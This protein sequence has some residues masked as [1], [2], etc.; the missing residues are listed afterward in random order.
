VLPPEVEEAF[1]VHSGRV[2]PRERLVYRPALLGSARLHFVDSRRRIDVWRSLRVLAPLTEGSSG[3]DPWEG[4]E[5]LEESAAAVVDAPLPGAAFA[6]LPEEATNPKSYAAWA[7]ALKAFVYRSQALTLWKAIALGVVSEPGESEAEFRI[8]LGQEARE[9]RDRQVEALRERH[10]PKLA[11]LQ[12]RIRKAETRVER[13]K[14]QYEQA[15]RQSWISIG[16]TILGALLGRKTVSVGTVGRATTAARGLGR[17]EQQKD[18]V[19]R[20][21]DSVESLR[22][23]LEALEQTFEEDVERIE[24]ALRPEALEL[25]P[26]EIRPRKSDIDVTR[27]VLAW[28]P[29]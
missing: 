12:E 28:V 3:L 23:K 9:E 19:D 29:A 5:V 6:A 17:A 18:D 15:K 21:R 7:R 11:R 27:P 25:E 26:I 22:E 8:R 16:A 24:E 1:V 10:A 4:A 20:A 13:E 14:S 2:S